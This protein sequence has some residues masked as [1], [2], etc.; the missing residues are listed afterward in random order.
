[1]AEAGVPE[2]YLAKVLG[3][4]VRAGVLDATRGVGGGY[5]LARPAGEIA[6]AEIVR[7][8]EGRRASPGCL[9]RSGEPCR[10]SGACSAHPAWAKVKAALERFLE[11]TTLAD[12]A[13][14]AAPLD[15][16]PSRPRR[17]RAP[18]RRSSPSKPRRRKAR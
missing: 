8:F 11:E 7:P 13:S 10:D 12:V 3:A 4:L 16:H 2:P 17:R 9:L 18:A 15:A 6:L 1:M 14:G 5:R